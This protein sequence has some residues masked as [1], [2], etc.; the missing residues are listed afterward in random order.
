[1]LFSLLRVAVIP[2]IIGNDRQRLPAVAFE[3]TLG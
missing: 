3:T 2:A 1:M